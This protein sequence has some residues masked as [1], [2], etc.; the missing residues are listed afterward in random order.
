MA[1][2]G[3]LY[4]GM[5]PN[6][7][8]V[9]VV[10][11]ERDPPTFSHC[12][13]VGALS[14]E[15]GRLC[16]MSRSDLSILRVA[17]A[18]HDVGKIGIPDTVLR[19]ETPFDAADWA[20]MKTHSAKSERIM[21]A[22]GLEHGPAI[23]LAVRHHHE[24]FNGEGYPDGLAGEAIPIFARIIAIA[25]A[26]D[27]MATLRCYRPARTHAQIMSVLGLEQGVRHDPYVFEK[28]SRLIRHSQFKA[29]ELPAE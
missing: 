27:A 12:G 18:F 11:D 19:K 29:Q 10:L 9:S 28:F 14:L 8:V 5:G 2:D 23:A 4:E 15:L 24:H 6:A 22:M 16:G 26:Y 1:P 7:G 21:L 13:R 25:D 17:A 20:L 3:A